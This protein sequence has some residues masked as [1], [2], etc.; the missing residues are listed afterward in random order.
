MKAMNNNKDPRK[1]QQML[2]IRISS[3]SVIIFPN[4]FEG[5]SFGNRTKETVGHNTCSSKGASVFFTSYAS[6]RN[7]L[8]SSNA[9]I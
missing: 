5:F 9:F 1:R 6:L 7:T 3:V 2:M 8:A 4:G